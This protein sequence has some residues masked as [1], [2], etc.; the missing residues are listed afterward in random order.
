M[1]PVVGVDH[2][3]TAFATEAYTLSP[4]P[5]ISVPISG[6]IPALKQLGSASSLELETPSTVSDHAVHMIV[7]ANY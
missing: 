5:S 6:S 1:V 3:P 4:G 2:A 7:V